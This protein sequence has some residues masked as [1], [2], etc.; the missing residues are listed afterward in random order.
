MM[1]VGGEH[2][3]NMAVFLDL[4]EPHKCPQWFSV[5]EKYIHTVT[6]TIKSE[7]QPR[8]TYDEV[9]A[10]ISKPTTAIEQRFLQ[11]NPPVRRIQ[12]AF[13]IGW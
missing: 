4:L 10:T 1:G 7:S 8:V 13:D 2:A 3:A 12:K 9:T 11:N 5:L 6:D